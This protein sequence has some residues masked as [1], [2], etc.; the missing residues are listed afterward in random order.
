MLKPAK[1][2]EDELNRIYLEKVFQNPDFYPFAF[3]V[4]FPEKLV[5]NVDSW[6]ELQYCSVDE[7]GN[8][9]GY[10]SADWSRPENHI[11]NLRWVYFD[12]PNSFSTTF[13]KDSEK[14]LKDLF[15]K[16]NIRKIKWSVVANSPAYLLYEKL[17]LKYKNV[18]LVGR[19]VSDIMLPNNELYDVVW[20]EMYSVRHESHSGHYESTKVFC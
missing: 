1:L 11:R 19:F 9:L 17:R 16:H 5:T 13:L 8:I 4:F 10:I 12:Y 3:N 14:F 6:S 15:I 2:Y 18:K 20:Y 7:D